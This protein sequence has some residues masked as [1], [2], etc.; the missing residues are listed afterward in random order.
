MTIARATPFRA[1]HGHGLAVV[2]DEWVREATAAH[3]AGAKTLLADISEFQP[4]I[5]DAA[6]LAW[7]KAIVIRAAYGAHHD[8]RA[9]FGGDRRKQLHDGGAQF[10][11]IYQYV[12]AN[13]DVTAQAREFC[14]LIGTLRAGEYPLAD[15]EEGAGDQSGRRAAWNRVVSGELGFAPGSG[16]SGLF[17]A[18][19]HNLAPVE[20]VAAYQ[21]AEPSP[22]HLLWQFTDRFQVPGV[23]MAD[24]SVFH[25]PV[26]E[27]AGHAYGGT[28]VNPP[29][30]PWT[31]TLVN[32]LPT[33]SAGS[34]GEDV[35][36][37]QGL[38]NAR[39]YTLAIDG[40]FGPAT[41]SAVTAF[42][43]AKG[44]VADGIIGPATWARL[45]NR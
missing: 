45:L 19:S 37:A 28:P 44:L 6:Y 30:I 13:E 7:S 29:V 20:W 27:L 34:S 5:N 9:W 42:Q 25:G 38:L 2:L 24:C 3:E 41:R 4:D 16:Y 10:L 33:L 31:E 36:S 15:W 26:T 21:A 14:R 11:G 43:H 39:G 17:F 35:K 22:P 8:D 12:T 23:G 18:D 40:V 1:G 32:N